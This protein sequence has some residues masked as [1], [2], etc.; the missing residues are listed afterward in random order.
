LL[1]EAFFSACKGEFYEGGVFFALA[2]K[3]RGTC[4]GGEGEVTLW[5]KNSVK[6]MGKI[7]GIDYR[8]AIQATVAMKLVVALQEYRTRLACGVP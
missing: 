6:G 5:I 7:L 1:V 3:G 8:G 4:R 2:S